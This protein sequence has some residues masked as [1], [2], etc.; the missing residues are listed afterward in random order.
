[1]T[2][3]RHRSFIVRT[4]LVLCIAAAPAA[5]KSSRDDERTTPTSTST[6]TTSTSSTTTTTTLPPTT[7]TIPAVTGGAVVK[8]AN[9]AGIDDAA[10]A[11]TNEL[12]LYGF[13]LRGPVNGFGVDAVLPTSKIYVLPGAEPV[14]GSIS[15][16][17]G[18]IPIF[19]MPTPVWIRG[20]SASLED[21]TVL[22]MLGQDRAGL[23]LGQ[24][25]VPPTTTTT[26]TTTTSTTTTVVGARR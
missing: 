15:R 24:M 7:T 19:Q 12:T 23:P 13:Q 4:M 2:A 5:C 25:G 9:S 8:I 3:P 11:L 21:A 20:G 1:M 16:L 18:G 6:T 10:T 26:S 17:M 14:A 22:V